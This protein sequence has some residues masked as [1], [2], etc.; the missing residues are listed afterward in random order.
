MS[1]SVANLQGAAG[2]SDGG[3]ILVIGSGQIDESQAYTE[4]WMPDGQ[5]IRIPTAT[6]KPSPAL[7]SDSP[8]FEQ[9]SATGTAIDGTI[10]PV[11]EERLVVS[12]RT[13]PTAKIRLR[14]DVQEYE[15][16]ISESLAART[17]DVER[18]VLNQVV[19]AAPGVRQEGQTTIY[20][21]VEERLILTK[22]LVL[23]EELRVTRRDTERLDT[24]TVQL[25][26]EVMLVE[27]EALAGAAGV[28]KTNP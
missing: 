9:A 12:K 1:D 28:L 23:R 18:I 21:L 24:R 17:F 20:P 16:T 2:A 25:Q 6:L 19:E 26:R 27:R 15:Q 4:L 7:P 14:K 5:I 8:A 22:E 3:N 10:I 13:V 11:V